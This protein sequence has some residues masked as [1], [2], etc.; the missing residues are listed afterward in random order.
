MVTM[1]PRNVI[2]MNKNLDNSYELMMP[3]LKP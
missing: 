1:A 3:S 2:Q